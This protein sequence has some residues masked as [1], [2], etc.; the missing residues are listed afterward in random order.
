MPN[1]TRK[2]S[3]SRQGK[4]RANWK[5]VLPAL[6]TCPQC[7]KPI[8]SHRICGFCGFYRGQQLVL[9]KEKPAKKK[10]A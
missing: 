9:I 1:P 10:Q 8:L 5:L 6:S 7:A 2:H 4:R 3:R